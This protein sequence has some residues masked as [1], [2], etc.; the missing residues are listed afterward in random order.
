MNTTPGHVLRLNKTLYGLEESPRI[1]FEL[2]EQEINEAELR[3]LKSA[4]FVFKVK[5]VLVT[6]FVN[7]VVLMSENILILSKIEK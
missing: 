1:C 3:L 5:G 7:D 6:C 2:H 4:V